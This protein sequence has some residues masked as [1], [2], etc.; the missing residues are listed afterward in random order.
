LF[1]YLFLQG[2]FGLNDDP[3]TGD[4]HLSDGST[5]AGVSYKVT[6][7][8]DVTGFVGVDGPA[9][10]GN[11]KGLSLTDVDFTFLKYTTG[12]ITYTAIKATGKDGSLIGFDSVQM[13]VFNV[14]ILLNATSEADND[15]VLNF[16]PPIT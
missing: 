10:S 13:G 16:T 3:V 14:S 8:L 7:A 4:L 9:S 15:P 5:L 11:A 1:D 2:E 6:S 12:S